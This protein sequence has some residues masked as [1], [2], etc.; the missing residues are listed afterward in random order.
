MPRPKL[1][2]VP[3]LNTLNLTKGRIA[4]PSRFFL[5]SIAGLLTEETFQPFLRKLSLEDIENMLAWDLCVIHEFQSDLTIG[6]EE[7]TSDVL[8]RFVVAAFR[9]IWPTQTTD[10]LFAQG[11]VDRGKPLKFPS[12]SATPC[13]SLTVP[14][15]AARAQTVFLEDCEARIGRTTPEI[16]CGASP[17]FPIIE[18]VVAD[19]LAGGNRF[20][21]IIVAVRLSEQ[22]YLD[23][24]PQLRLMKRAMAL[25][26][27]F[28]TGGTY[29]KRAL[30]YRVPKF[31]GETTPIYPTTSTS[32]SVG[33]VI[34]DICELRNA[35]AHGDTV[36]AK[37]LCTPPEPSVRSVNVRS[38]ADVLREAS[39]V[40]LRQCLLKIFTDGLADTFSD[41]LKMEKLF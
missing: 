37:F 14:Q 7:R 35:F 30:V 11:F 31:L 12:F 1:R 27:L 5:D 20:I 36:P 39:A 17:F 32:Y 3:L 10:T 13:T 8:M 21:P 33:A 9:W 4:L 34:S 2:I 22:A 29:G 6:S 16:F 25:E 15:F 26:A 41:K 23:F 40:I 18:R 38:Y 24:D 19:I 28:S